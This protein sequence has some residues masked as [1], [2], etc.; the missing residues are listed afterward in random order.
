[1]S[2]FGVISHSP[3]RYLLNLTL[4]DNVSVKDS[5]WNY[6]SVGTYFFSLTK[7]SALNEQDKGLAEEKENGK[8]DENPS[9]EKPVK[10]APIA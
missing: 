7:K 2:V 1:M 8:S 6:E 10:T 3:V 9:S 5:Y 4:S